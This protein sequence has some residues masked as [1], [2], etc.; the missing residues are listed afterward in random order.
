M[1][2]KRTVL[3]TG[4][5]GAGTIEILRTLRALERYRVIAVDAS[6]HAAGFQFADAAYTVPMASEPQFLETMTRLME[7]EQP[8]FVIPLV[9]EEIL[10]VHDLAA[11]Y[12]AKVVGPTAAF[13]RCCLDKWEMA[14]ALTAEGI[15]AAP[16]WL[17]TEPAEIE[18]PAVIKPRKGRGSRGVAYLDNAA[19]LQR[20]LSA[21]PRPA[22]EYLV[23]R[24]L[25]GREYTISV[26]VALGGPVLAVVPKEVLVKRGITQ[27]GVTRAVPAIE[28]LCRHIQERLHADGPFNVQ[29]IM[30]AE[31]IPRIIEINPRYS[32]TVAL[33][34]AAGIHEVD[35]VIRHALGEV[36][37]PLTFQPNLLMVRSA[38]H[39]YLPEEEWLKS[40][41][42][43]P[44]EPVLLQES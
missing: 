23:Q 22:T 21:V 27:V 9:D 19:D 17:A 3:I 6:P 44:T 5:G 16:T 29:L 41:V 26:V 34:I 39:C 14:L 36:V 15:P 40:A 24:R 32:T 38:A 28:A 35:V 2:H 33:T 43:G 18:Y 4:A 8:E 11:R 31:G 30:D 37:E 1:R 42:K 25:Y 20:Y 12:G 13:C 10:I 7:Q